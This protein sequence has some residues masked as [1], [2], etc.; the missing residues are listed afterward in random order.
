V[1]PSGDL[2]AVF[3]QLVNELSSFLVRVLGL[4]VAAEEEEEEEEEPPPPRVLVLLLFFD[5]TANAE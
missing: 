3:M 1:R 5:L 4:A 2:F